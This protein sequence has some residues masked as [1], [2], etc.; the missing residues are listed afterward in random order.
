MALASL[1]IVNDDIRVLNKNLS[2][3]VKG[4][5]TITYKDVTEMI[6]PQIILN[7]D[8][9]NLKNVNYVYLSDKQRFYFVDGSPQLLTGNRILYNLK[10]DVRMSHKDIIK[11]LT[12]TITRNENKY[13]QYLPDNEYK[14]LTYETISTHLFPNSVDNNSII[15]MTTG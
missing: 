2:N 7:Y 8:N 10:C 9:V 14:V 15:L 4:D 1:Y 13:N 11:N 6:R 12:A 5:V 3:A